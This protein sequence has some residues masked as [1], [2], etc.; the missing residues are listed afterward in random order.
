MP[1]MKL[2]HLLAIM[3]LCCDGAALSKECT[4]RDIQFMVATFDSKDTALPNLGQHVASTVVL[5]VWQ[6]LRQPKTRTGKSAGVTWDITSPPPFSFDDVG[7]LASK[8]CEDPQML[9]WGRT[10]HYGDG[11]ILD[12]SLA[13]RSPKN[14]KRS[15]GQLWSAAVGTAQPISVGLPSQLLDFKPVVLSKN[16]LTELND[17]A[18]LRLYDKKTCRSVTDKYVGDYF[19]ADEFTRIDGQDVAIV[20]HRQGKK[21]DEGCIRMPGLSL[22]RSNPVNFSGGLVAFFRQEWAYAKFLLIPVAN[23][24]GERKAVRATALLYIGMASDYL[25]EDTI[26]WIE[27]AYNLNPYELDAI[28]YYC[29]ARLRAIAKAGTDAGTKTRHLQAIARILTQRAALFPAGDH[30]IDSVWSIVGTP[31]KALN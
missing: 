16:L 14:S 20:S 21:P 2:V 23:D 25:G 1:M 10:W 7:A 6:T 26:P 27:E 4:P 22:Q 5:Q 30:W 8:I 11:Y 18:F 24:I 29:V 19:Q 9:M 12:P 13:I 17:P 31:P 28:E 3:L 15:L